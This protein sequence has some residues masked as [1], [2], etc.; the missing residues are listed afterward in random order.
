[1]TDT[2][3][4]VAAVAVRKKKFSNKPQG[5]LF[6]DLKSSTDL[7]SLKQLEKIDDTHCYSAAATMSFFRKN[8]PTENNSFPWQIYLS[9][10]SSSSSSSSS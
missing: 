8:Y 9:I 5:L 3:V 7:L 1:V 6:T 2:T 10:S 4:V